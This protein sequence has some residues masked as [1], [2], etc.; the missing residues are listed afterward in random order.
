[1]EVGSMYLNFVDIG[2]LIIIAL[3]ALVGFKNGVTKQLVS[4]I[5]FIAVI[6]LSFLL[7]NIV[8]GLLYEYLPFINFD[9]FFK[10]AS[11]FNI[12][13]YEIIGFIVIFSLLMIILRILL[14]ITGVFETILKYTIILGIPSKIF[15]AIVGAVEYI[16]YTFVILYFL[17]LPTFDIKE[18]KNSAIADKILH[19]TP[20]LSDAVGSGLD[21]YKEIDNLVDKYNGTDQVNEFNKEAIKL[22]LD[23]KIISVSSLEKLIDSG[24]LK[25]DG[26]D[27][28]IND[29]K[30][31]NNGNS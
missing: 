19:T 18:V 22:Y 25:V 27:T 14:K 11:S 17:S 21:V 3:G 15:G 13:F 1:M 16:C 12:L 28:I 2:I 8:S 26:I 10:G 5:G 29:Y 4:F 30:E 24:K 6:V 31:E 23:Y 9:T 7:K 20:I